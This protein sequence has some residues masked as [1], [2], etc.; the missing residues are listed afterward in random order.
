MGDL[1][2]RKRIHSKVTQ[3]AA[4]PAAWQPQRDLLLLQALPKERTVAETPR[5]VLPQ[6][7]EDWQRYRRWLIAAV[8]PD[9][10]D[11][12]LLPGAEIIITRLSALPMD[13]QGETWAFVREA[14]VQAILP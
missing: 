1:Q 12:A 14:D 4:P 5:L 10:Q 11:P 8:G 2:S 7:T 3:Q 9:V 6:Q 13:W